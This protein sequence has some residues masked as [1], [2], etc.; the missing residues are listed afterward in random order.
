MRSL[1]EYAHCTPYNKN[2]I[3]LSPKK[4]D[5]IQNSHPIK[6]LIE[7]FI[8]AKM[9]ISNCEFHLFLLDPV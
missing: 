8:S 7:F 3:F 1:Q 4:L 5:A 6:I 2:Y 9:N